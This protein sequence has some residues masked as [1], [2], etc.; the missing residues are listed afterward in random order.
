M[1]KQRHAFKALDIQTLQFKKY[2]A[3]SVKGR[4]AFKDVT[5]MEIDAIK[6]RSSQR[7]PEIVA[8]VV[9]DV[10]GKELDF[11]KVNTPDVIAIGDEATVNGRPA[12]GNYVLPDGTTWK[13]EK[14]KL[15][16]ITP[17]SDGAE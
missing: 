15:T 6:V 12:S 9:Q 11:P 16:K 8:C 4:T 3:K 2:E 7:I 5:S 17:P 10:D 13:F 14:G 1:K